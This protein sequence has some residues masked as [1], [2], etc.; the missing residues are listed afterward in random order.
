MTASVLE[1]MLWYGTC[2]TK[3]CSCSFFYS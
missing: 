3:L 2:K 1:N